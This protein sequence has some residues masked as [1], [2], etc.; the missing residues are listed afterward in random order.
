[1]YD[2]TLI[3][4][5]SIASQNSTDKKM[6]KSLNF[7]THAQVLNKH[8]KF[9]WVS[10]V[11]PS[12]EA[13]E[14]AI[15]TWGKREISNSVDELID[16]E[17]Y[18]VIV[19]ATP[20]ENRL[21]V[22]KHFPSLKAIVVEKPLGVSYLSS[23]KFVEECEKRDIKVQVNLTRRSDRV[24]R[25]LASGDLNKRIGNTQFVFGSYG[26][27]LHNYG[28]H[29][30]DLVRMLIGEIAFVSSLSN[31]EKQDLGPI[32]NDLNLSFL[33]KT[34]DGIQIMM[35]PLDF[36]FY[37]EGSLDIWGEKGRLEIIQEGLKYIESPLDSCRS[38]EG[39]LE[40]ASDRRV[41]HDTGYADALFH[42]YTNL[43][44]SISSDIEL[45]SSGRSALKTE[46]IIESLFRSYKEN[47]K[48]ISCL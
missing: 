40:I 9:N 20:P 19:L 36:S 24:M 35:H 46:M 25:D 38:L 44:N 2:T 45:N 10:A 48:E 27:G 16:K 11:D 6:L 37:R 22:I 31:H 39:A 17:R 5:G 18:E 33:M 41:S 23:L 7:F 14:Y 32:N 12:K 28:P 47:G 43:S 29:L 3:G 26:R 42:L 1:M 21:E 30:I 4:L 34:L 15:K 13:R 8:Q